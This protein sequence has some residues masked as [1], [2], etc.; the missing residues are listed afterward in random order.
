MREGTHISWGITDTDDNYHIR[1]NQRA[2]LYGAYIGIQQLAEADRMN[3]S[4]PSGLQNS[5]AV[6]ARSNKR[7]RAG[8]GGQPVGDGT[9]EKEK[10]W[11]VAT[12]SE[13]VVKG[14]TEWLPVWEASTFFSRYRYYKF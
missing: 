7:R 4:N 12:D 1:S 11:I 2:E 10:C 6:D 9:G 13:Y 5:E 14:M 3:R 8:T